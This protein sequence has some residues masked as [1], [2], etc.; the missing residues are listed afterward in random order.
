MISKSVLRIVL[1][2]F[3]LVLSIPITQAQYRAGIQGVVLDAQGNTITGATVTLTSKETNKANQSTSDSAGVY[4]FLSLPPG[5]Y[6]I[7]AEMTG[8]KKKVMENVIVEAEQTQ[9]VNITL[10]VGDVTQQV[11]VTADSAPAIDT[12]TGNISGTL[13]TKEIQN[14]PSFNRDRKS[15]RLNSSHSQISYAVFC[16]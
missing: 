14:L 13:N 3:S 11:L 4:N 8:F 12:Q 16:L 9:G 2:L 5:R 10:E 6:R 7:E 15:T 1:V